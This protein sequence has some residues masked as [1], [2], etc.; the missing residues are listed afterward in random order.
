MW[1]QTITENNDLIKENALLR[2]QR[3]TSAVGMP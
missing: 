3:A 1:Q 2:Q